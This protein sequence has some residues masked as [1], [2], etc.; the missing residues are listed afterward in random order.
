MV[1]I[2]QMCAIELADKPKCTLCGLTHPGRTSM[3]P[4]GRKEVVRVNWR[5]ERGQSWWEWREKDG[6]AGLGRVSRGRAIPGFLH[7]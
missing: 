3:K 6:G 2:G 7:R 5:D 1:A 4:G